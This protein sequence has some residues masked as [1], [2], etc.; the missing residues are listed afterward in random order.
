MVLRKRQGN[1]PLGDAD[2]YGSIILKWILEKYSF[3]V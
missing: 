3:R 1:R 2:V